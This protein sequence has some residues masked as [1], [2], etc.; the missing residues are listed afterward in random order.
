MKGL[1]RTP[2][3]LSHISI[4]NPSGAGTSSAHPSCLPTLECSL[5]VDVPPCRTTGHQGCHSGGHQGLAPTIRMLQT[6]LL[7]ASNDSWSAWKEQHRKTSRDLPAMKAALSSWGLP[8]H[9]QD[10]GKAFSLHCPFSLSSHIQAAAELSPESSLVPGIS[11]QSFP[12]A[13]TQGKPPT[14]SG[15]TPSPGTDRQTQAGLPCPGK[16]VEG[17]DGAGREREQSLAPQTSK[18][19]SAGAFGTV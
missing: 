7:E 13:P 12:P 16:G 15:Q 18:S 17:G 2:G 5:Q 4:L 3:C 6:Q 11:T 8:G 19:S 1:S 9:Q 10:Q 14:P